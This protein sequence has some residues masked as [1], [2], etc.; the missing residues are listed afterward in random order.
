M[1]ERLPGWLGERLHLEPIAAALRH[2]TVPQHRYS[3]WYYFG[4]MT[5]FLFAIQVG[6]GALLLLYYRPSAG[7]A[8]ESVQFI[9]T[10]VPFGWLI[11]SIHAWSANL[12]VLAA[13][14]HMFSVLFL[15]AYRRPREITWVS[16]AGLLFLTLAFGFTGY[17]LP[18]N[19]LSYF[20]TR[21]GTE[22][23]G[24]VP[25][26][27]EF[28]VRLL[29]G[30][31]DVTGATLTR[32][33]GIHVAIL[34]AITFA[35]L[36]LHLW[37]IQAH[38]MSLPPSVERQAQRGAPVA[39]VPFVPHFALREL[40]GW[41]VV[42][43]FLAGLSA[44]MPWELG[45]KADL[46]APAPAGIRPEWYFLWTFQTLKYMPARVLG[47]NGELL[48][49]AA[50]GLA[51]AALVA[52]PFLDRNTPQ[53]RRAVALVAAAIAVFMIAM[54]MLALQTEST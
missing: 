42:L 28:S 46:F 10:R 7:E 41:T 1:G 4:G 21:V 44:L 20:A 40:F 17:L 13:V 16:G 51:A 24:A 15:S 9:M 30:G 36:A 5:L 38:G 18:W 47:I 14:A 34:P 8:Y 27:G 29:R 50:F 53:S 54:T 32:F 23:G 37:L 12:M 6:S 19:E 49:I 2:K 43:A 35:A 26:V 11:R 3:I 25:V 31:R 33:F 39:S 22:V 45:K 48:A 52:L